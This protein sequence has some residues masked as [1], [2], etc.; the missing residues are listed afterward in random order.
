[1]KR[2]NQ[3]SESL[4]DEEKTSVRIQKKRWMGSTAKN[5]FDSAMISVERDLQEHQ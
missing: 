4:R 5:A 1:M 2:C 3:H